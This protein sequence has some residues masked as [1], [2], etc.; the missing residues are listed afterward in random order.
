MKVLATNSARPLKR[1]MKMII[2]SRIRI[3]A[4]SLG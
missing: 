2:R 1:V 4:A 3:M